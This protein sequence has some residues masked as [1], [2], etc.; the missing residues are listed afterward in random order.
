MPAYIDLTPGVVPVSDSGVTRLAL[1][2]GGTLVTSVN[3]GAFGAPSATLPA[4]TGVANK[5]VSAIAATGAG[6]LSALG[7]IL[8]CTVAAGVAAAGP[9]T[10]TGTKVG[11]KVVGVADLT[12][13]A[14]A[15]ASFEA[16][17]TV[18]DQIQQSSASDLSAVVFQ[19]IVVKQS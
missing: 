3:G 14:D 19:F 9:V 15:K 17:V 8:L 1:G 18:A 4:T 5:F 16:T 10:V 11:D 6:T 2:A 12:N 7:A 13:L